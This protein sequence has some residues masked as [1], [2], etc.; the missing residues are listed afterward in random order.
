MR[1]VQIEE[2]L[3]FFG[4]TR[5]RRSCT[6]DTLAT[7]QVA[8]TTWCAQREDEM[9]NKLIMQCNITRSQLILALVV[10]FQCFRDVKHRV[11]HVLVKLE[12]LKR[13]SDQ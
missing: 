4:G 10:S 3:C 2:T 13:S 5:E 11:P 9:E 7:G 1:E 8:T 6:F 12:K